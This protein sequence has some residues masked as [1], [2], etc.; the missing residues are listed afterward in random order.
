[1]TPDDYSPRMAFLAPPPDEESATARV[2]EFLHA[3]EGMAPIV[4]LLEAVRDSIAGWAEGN[5]MS[6]ESLLESKAQVEGALA[7][8]KAGSGVPGLYG[9]IGL[10]FSGLEQFRKALE[11]AG[12]YMTAHEEGES[13]MV[14][15][16]RCEVNGKDQARWK[17]LLDLK[18]P[19]TLLEVKN[20]WPIQSKKT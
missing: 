6:L 14:T 15:S 7:F 18:G 16:Y 3:S 20:A 9:L 13:P 10:K 2:A 5:E 12:W 11:Q 8:A 17:M 19:G 4:S 1:M